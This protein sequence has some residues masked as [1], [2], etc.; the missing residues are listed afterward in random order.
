METVHIGFLLAK[1]NGLKIC[2]ANISSAFLYSKTCKRWY[3]IAGPEFGLL[4]GEKMVIDKGLHRLQT[5]SV[6]FHEHLA[7]KLQKMGYI[8][9]K[10]NADFW[11]NKHKDR[12]YKYIANYVDD[13]ISFS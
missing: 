9:S 8:P 4:K 13:V 11:K 3:I 10:A 5:S 2:A 6:H 7:C 1:M 12:H